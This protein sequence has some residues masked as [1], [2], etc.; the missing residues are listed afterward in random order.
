MHIKAHNFIAEHIWIGLFLIQQVGFALL[1][2][3]YHVAKPFCLDLLCR[4]SGDDLFA[5]IVH[6]DQF[7]EKG[8]KEIVAHVQVVVCIDHMGE[9]EAVLNNLFIGQ[10]AQI[11][12]IAWL[13]EQWRIF[14]TRHAAGVKVKPEP[15]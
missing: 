15:L 11:H 7:L 9:V 8:G 5:D 12:A 3:F 13:I 10:R 4:L 1:F 14:G 2:K 6:A